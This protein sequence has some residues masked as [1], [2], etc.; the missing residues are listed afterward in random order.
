M[1]DNH[2][3]E[4]EGLWQPNHFQNHA[5]T[6]ARLAVEQSDGEILI[7]SRTVIAPPVFDFGMRCTYIWRIA[8]DG[9]VNVALSGERFGDYPHIIPCIGFTMGINGEYDQVASTVI[10]RRKLHQQPANIIDIW[11]STVDAMF[12]NYPFRRTTATVG[13]HLRWTALTNRHGNGLLVVP[14]RPINFERLALY[15]GKHPR[16]PAL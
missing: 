6:S 7:I 10:N 13:G 1:I 11:R 5:G 12:E 16:C 3:Q 2:K 8:A 14:Q 4:Y 15:P 9:Q